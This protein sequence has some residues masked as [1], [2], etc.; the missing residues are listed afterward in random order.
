MAT[1]E[2]RLHVDLQDGFEDE[3]VLVHVDGEPAYRNETV[4][5]DYRISRAASFEQAV[6]ADTALVEVSLPRRGLSDSRQVDVSHTPYLGISILDG[7]IRWRHSPVPF[8]YM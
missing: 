2:R 7:A 5:T 1:R 4:R 3:P 8:G 6:T